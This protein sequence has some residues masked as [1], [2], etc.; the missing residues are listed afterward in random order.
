[1]Y[2][3]TNPNFQFSFFCLIIYHGFEIDI[4]EMFKITHHDSRNFLNL[5]ATNVKNSPNMVGEIF[6][7]LHARNVKRDHPPWLEKI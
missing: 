2:T 6:L 5:H 7:N 4:P 1:M 3:I